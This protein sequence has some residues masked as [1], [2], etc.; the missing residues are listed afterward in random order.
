MK[1]ALRAAFATAGRVDGIW[2]AFKA[3]DLLAR[4]LAEPLREADLARRAD[5]EAAVAQ[6]LSPA[7][8]VL[9]GPFKD[10]RYPTAR[11][12]G[13]A[14]IPKI[15]GSYER[16]LHPVVERVLQTGYS[17][18]V[19][20]GCA[21]GW[22]AVGLAMRLQG[23]QVHAFD[24]DP[25]ARELCRSMAEANDV[26]DRVTIRSHCSE[27]ALMTLALGPRA[28]VVSDCEG[29]ES[30]LFTADVAR[31]LARHDLLIEVHD[32]F[33][34]ALGPRL[35]ERFA[36]THEQLVIDS[37]DDT[38]KLRSYDFPELAT[39]DLAA[40]RQMLSEG[41]GMVMEWLFLTSRHRVGD[42]RLPAEGVALAA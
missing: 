31:R 6:A 25:D 4:C 22:Y 34:P 29:Y 23:V 16:E 18:V 1:R 11:A 17:D 42:R 21:E 30:E 19:D 26:A 28:L 38:R 5:R 24:T 35:R 7:L 39:F 2:H 33:D 27:Q 12:A 20:I 15:L 3:L 10:M 41:R 37:I 14:L 32:R 9:N 36:A 8:T 40:R 13:S